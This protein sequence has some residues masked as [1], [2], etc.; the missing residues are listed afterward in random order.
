MTHL[1]SFVPQGPARMGRAFVLA[2]LPLLSMACGTAPQAAPRTEECRGDEDCRE[3]GGVCVNNR[4]QQCRESTDCG[5][6]QQCVNNRCT[7]AT[8]RAPAEE[9]GQVTVA[10]AESGSNCFQ[11]VHFAFDDAQLS[12]AARRELQQTAECLRREG[13]SRYVLIGRADPRGTTEYNLALGERRARSVQRY[14]VALGIR[15]ARL[16]V[17]SEGSE[18]ATGTDEAGWQQDRRVEYNNR[19]GNRGARGAN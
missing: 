16:A 5:E 19:E 9:P 14:L 6:G 1:H 18:G 17:S 7:A 3:Q 11:N 15:E 2:L 13:N 8:S 4:C 12:D 10:P